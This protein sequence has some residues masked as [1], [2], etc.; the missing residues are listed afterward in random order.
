MLFVPVMRSI[1]RLLLAV[2]QDTV[3][4]TPECAYAS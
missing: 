3:R 4:H 1:P 2:E